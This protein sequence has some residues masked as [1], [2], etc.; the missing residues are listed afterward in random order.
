MPARSSRRPKAAP[1]RG[2]SR[3][4]Y[5]D[6]TLRPLYC[7]AFLLPLL[8]LYE[9]GILLAYPRFTHEQAPEVMAKVLLSWFMS[10][11]GGTGYYLPGLFVVAVLLAWHLIRRDPWRIDRRVLLGMTGESVLLAL[12]MLVFHAVLIARV[13]LA[14][15]AWADSVLLSMSAGI[16]EELVFRLLLISLLTFLLS[17]VAGLKRNPA[18]GAAVVLSSVIFA[19]HHCKGFGGIEPFIWSRFVFRSAAGLYLAGVFVLRG[20]G[21]AVGCHTV[22][23]II[24]VSMD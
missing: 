3:G 17:D 14:G 10:F 9:L 8:I 20:F 16:Y 15:A 13:M 22:Y 18:A 7:L 23:D 19:A 1:P 24:V 4:G 11:F 12:P 6:L 2:P 5:L 21:I